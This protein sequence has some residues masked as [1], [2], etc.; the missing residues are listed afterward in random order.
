MI[1]NSQEFII[2]L[3]IVVSLFYASPHKY[4]KLILLVSSYIFYGWWNPTYLILIWA[5]TLTDFFA[6]KSIYLS[7]NQKNRRFFLILSIIVNL[8]I[9]FSFKYANF[10]AQ[11]LNIVKEGNTLINVLLPVGISFYT[12]QTMSY[13]IDVYKKK[14][15]P[16]KN[17]LNF[18]LFVAFF[19][20]LVAGPIERAQNIIPQIKKK[21]KFDAD[22]FSIGIYLILLG[23]FQK[24]VVADNL[25]V[26]V[27]T[28][29]N[30]PTSYKGIDVLVAAIFFAFQIY[31]DFAGYTNI[32]RGV[33]LFFGVK[34][35]VNFKQP[36][37]ANSIKDFWHR[38]HIS[39]ST[40]FRDYIYIPLGGSKLP[41]PKW[42][43]AIS[44]TFILSGFWHGANWTFVIW[45]ILNAVIYVAEILL[46]KFFNRNSIKISKNHFVNLFRIFIA[47]GGAVLLWITF[48]ANSVNDAILIY[49]NLFYPKFTISFD[50][51]WMILNFG[52]ILSLICIDLIANKHCFVNW[53][54]KNNTFIRAAFIYFFLLM[55]IFIGNWHH[56]PFIYFQ[57]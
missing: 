18:A 41:I 25:S 27:D 10:V 9:L 6:A 34:L 44:L 17:I 8:G 14:L 56:T 12:F 31:A 30:N 24:V 53:L 39:L 21:I 5:S 13:T 26:F 48:R 23:F 1:F 46:R 29:F 37:L 57:F 19:P 7:N 22:R 50:H 54:H 47:F 40:W 35:S 20:Q 38:W 43:L 55:I 11:T 51:K 3:I 16:E 15:K 4:R 33:A 36:Y 49:K 45:G 32:A 28:V 52:L 2:F 42:I